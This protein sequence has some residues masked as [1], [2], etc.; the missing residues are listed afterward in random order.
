MKASLEGM[1]KNLFGELAEDEIRW[2]D[3]YFPFTEP[4][5]E[6][7]IMWQG[8]W[9]EVLGCGIMQQKILEGSGADAGGTKKAWA[10]GIGLER[11]AMP[12]FKIPDIRIFWS[13]NKRFL[14]QFE[15]G[16]IKDFE[17]L[18]GVKDFPS[19]NKDISMWVPEGFADND[20]FDMI[21]N[22]EYANLIEEVELFDE[23]TNPKTGRNSKA[24]H[25]VFR[26]PERTLPTEEVNVHMEDLRA[27]AVEVLGVE[28]R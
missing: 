11:I 2:V 12:L 1:I 23:F 8:E 27:Q 14:S 5:W 18:L 4:S 28:L 25:V 3:A 7:E 22:L 15:D 24:F 26:S 17:P 13:E 10:F 16:E 20:F 6:M 9:L 21:Q 19:N